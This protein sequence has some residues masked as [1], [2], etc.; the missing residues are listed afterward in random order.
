MI[1]VSICLALCTW[2]DCSSSSNF[3]LLSIQFFFF[4]FGGYVFLA[5]SSSHDRLLVKSFAC[6]FLLFR[7]IA[8][9]ERRLLI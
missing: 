4:L 1:I 7:G 8:L 5:P 3:S 2:P 6:V 9:D